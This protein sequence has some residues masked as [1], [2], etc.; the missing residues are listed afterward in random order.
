[1]SDTLKQ[2]QLDKFKE[3][4]KSVETDDNEAAFDRA[5]KKIGKPTRDPKVAGKRISPSE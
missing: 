4:A 2:S 5:L 1:M 3:L